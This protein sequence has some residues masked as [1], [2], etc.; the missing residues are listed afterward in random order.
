MKSLRSKGDRLNWTPLKEVK[1][2]RLNDKLTQ[3]K[4]VKLEAVKQNPKKNT[5]LVP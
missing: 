5:L 3:G 4:R 1:S 2:V